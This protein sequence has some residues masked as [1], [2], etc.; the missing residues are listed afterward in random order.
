MCHV[1]IIFQL[2]LSLVS[3]QKLNS[4]G[5]L[6]KVRIIMTMQSESIKVLHIN[7]LCRVG[8]QAE[9]GGCTRG[10]WLNIIKN[11]NI[12]IDA[13]VVSSQAYTKHCPSLP[14]LPPSYTF[15]KRLRGHLPILT[16][17]SSWIFHSVQFY[18]KF[19]STAWQTFIRALLK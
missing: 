10:S 6:D 12:C 18:L 3:L 14:Y 2:W 17:S 9:V 15:R 11:N 8:E 16:F 19:K 4:N 7:S 1:I 13:D 5:D